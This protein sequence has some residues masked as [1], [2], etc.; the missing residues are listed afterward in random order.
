MY[1][2]TPN[3]AETSIF[4]QAWCQAV[5][6]DTTFFVISGGNHE[7]ICARNRRDQTM[8][9]SS[10]IELSSKGYLK[11]QVGMYLAA[12]E[13]AQDRM[14]RKLNHNTGPLIIEGFKPSSQS[15][16]RGQS[17]GKDQEDGHNGCEDSKGG[18]TDERTT[19]RARQPSRG[20][21]PQ[22][23]K[24]LSQRQQS[25]DKR[26]REKGNPSLSVKQV[27]LSYLDFH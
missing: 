25:G 14:Q 23:G 24:G 21:G 17:H 26:Q 9:M 16:S 20:R 12:L 18:D 10:L 19:K 11:T 8:H 22:R 2:P 4:A 15:A 3:V 5:C 6:Y 1:A 7:F 27:G 13:D